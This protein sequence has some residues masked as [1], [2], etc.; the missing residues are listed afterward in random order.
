MKLDRFIVWPFSIEQVSQML[1][2]VKKK[3]ACAE[4][5]KQTNIRQSLH[6]GAP[7]EKNG[8]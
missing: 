5:G 2:N 7:Y 3:G 6:D 1:E 4:A 8:L